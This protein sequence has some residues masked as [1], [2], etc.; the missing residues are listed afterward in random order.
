MAAPAPAHVVVPV[1]AATQ[2]AIANADHAFARAE[3]EV[4]KASA[5][6]AEQEAR[7]ALVRARNEVARLRGREENYARNPN[8][9][10]WQRVVMEIDAMPGVPTWKEIERQVD[11]AFESEF[12]VTEARESTTPEQ[13]R[14]FRRMFTLLGRLEHMW[15]W[16]LERL[17]PSVHAHL[18]RR[19]VARG[20]LVSQAVHVWFVFRFM[21]DDTNA[22]LRELFG[23]WSAMPR[24]P[25]ALDPEDDRYIMHRLTG[26]QA[27]R[28]LE[29]YLATEFGSGGG[30]WGSQHLRAISEW[31]EA[32]L[33][34]AIERKTARP[35]LAQSGVID[36]IAA[37][38]GNDIAQHIARL[39]APDTVTLA[40]PLVVRQHALQLEQLRATMSAADRPE[41]VLARATRQLE[42]LLADVSQE[43]SAKKQRRGE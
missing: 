17:F 4:R 20:E 37:R 30:V 31:F 39:V 12:A 16:A 3:A 9:M 11:A 23:R 7:N 42:H 6:A 8:E 33:R 15:N 1:P 21:P 29:V 27:V 41:A 25:G 13:A 5:P 19:E 34:A 38:Q 28:M 10:P 2:A 18:Q 32:D 43:T 40:R 22:Q 36:L 24:I 35:Y 14:Q 26:A